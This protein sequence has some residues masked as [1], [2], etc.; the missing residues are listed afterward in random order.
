MPAIAAATTSTAIGNG[1]H[2]EKRM[3]R[4]PA[5]VEQRPGVIDEARR[6]GVEHI[7]F[8]SARAR[9]AVVVHHVDVVLELAARG[10]ERIGERDVDVRVAAVVADGDLA[11]GNADRQADAEPLLVTV[12]MWD[13]DPHVA[14]HQLV[15]EVLEPLDPPIDRGLDG[16]ATGKTVKGHTYRRLHA[17]T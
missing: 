10:D 2:L 3:S 9:F 17:W 5:S 14:M 12:V 4:A 16:L 8:L 11:P 1:A 6:Q 13:I 15:V 7:V